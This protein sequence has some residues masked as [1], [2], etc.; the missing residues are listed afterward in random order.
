MSN[1]LD[2]SVLYPKDYICAADLGGGEVTVT[3]TG[4]RKE[5]V[6]MSGNKKEP[7]VILSM[8][9][10][11]K[12]FLA[13]KTNGLAMAMLLSPAGRKPSAA[14]WIGKRVVLR[15]DMDTF[16]RDAVA[17]IRV[18]GSPDAAPDDAAEFARVWDRGDRKGGALAGRLKRALGIKITKGGANPPPPPKVQPPTP[19]PD[20]GPDMFDPG[21]EETPNAD[22][23]GR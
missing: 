18:V 20:G 21:S 19:E 2:L 14:D 1:D 22:N 12:K 5:D 15:T 11:R 17:S 10:T 7:A 13:N 6:P 4:V 8:K 9:G 23:D 3:I 16:G